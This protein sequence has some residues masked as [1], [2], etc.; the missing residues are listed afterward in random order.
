MRAGSGER[1]AASM[2][3]GC[4][5]DARGALPVLLKRS[6]AFVYANAVVQAT[7]LPFGPGS[8][9]DASYVEGRW[10]PMLTCVHESGRRPVIPD[11]SGHH[12]A[13][14]L[15][16][17]LSLSGGAS[18]SSQ[19]EFKLSITLLNGIENGHKKS[20]R[21]VALARLGMCALD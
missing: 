9:V 14:G 3:G 1:G 17:D 12:A 13:N 16:K 6:V 11:T 19:T 15:G 21:L 18:M 20:D 10:S 8:A 5:V 4:R 7:R 2:G